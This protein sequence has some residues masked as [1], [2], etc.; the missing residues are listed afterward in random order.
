MAKKG[1]QFTSC[2]LEFKL[3]MVEDYFNRQSSSM[4]AIAK[5]YGFKSDNQVLTWIQKHREN[6]NFLIQDLRGSKSIGRPKS[7]NLDDMILGEQNAYLRM[8]NDIL[9][10]INL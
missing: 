8:E 4:K 1:S 10:I 9:K 7:A 5:K 3:Q 2:V 6:P